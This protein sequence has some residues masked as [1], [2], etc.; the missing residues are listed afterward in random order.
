VLASIRA[1]L[2]DRANFDANAESRGLPKG[3]G[4]SHTLGIVAIALLI[5]VAV[6]GFA[7]AMYY[8]PH[9]DAAYESVRYID[10]QLPT[11]ALV[12]GL[13]HWGTA[14]LTVVLGLHL[15]RSYIHAAYKPPRELIWIS[16]LVLLTLVMGFG[17]TGELLPWDQDAYH[18]TVVRTRYAEE[19]PVIGPMAATLLRGGKEIGALTLT[20]FYAVHILLLPVLVTALLAAH[21]LWVRRFGPTLPQTR[22]GEEPAPAPGVRYRQMQ[23]ALWAVVVV[24]GVV[25]ALAASHP[26]ELDFKADPTDSSYH[27]RAEWHLMFLFQLV[28]DFQKIPGI[29][30]YSWIPA[31]ILPGIAMTFLALAPWIDR[32][33]ERSPARRPFMMGALALA[34]LGVAGLTVRAYA[35]LKPNATPAHSLYGHFTNGD[36]TPLNQEQVL[37]GAQAF[38]MCSGCHTAY[39]DYTTGRSGPDLT[40]YGRKNIP[41]TELPNHPDAHS[42]SYY[43]RYAQYLRGD[44][45]P[46]VTRMPKYTEEM[47]PKDRLDAIGAYLS[48]DPSTAKRLIGADEE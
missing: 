40:G 28:Q 16:G 34:V 31:V 29:G 22:V 47:L 27:P 2:T 41:L 38:A 25:F 8:S 11:G 39:Q 12:H 18:G 6:T 10:K 15:L 20:R 19:I 24:F 48:Q 21:V 1:W 43:D 4:W 42:L 9:P 36:R 30:G 3:V 13:H 46:E 44:L 17:I 14:A 7:M 33:P 5:V 23:R 26:V 32:G 35:N 37:A 45:R